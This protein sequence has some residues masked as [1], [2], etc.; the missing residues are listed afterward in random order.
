M[1]SNQKIRKAVAEMVEQGLDLLENDPPNDPTPATK[2]FR[3]NRASYYDA[4]WA[5]R[6]AEQT[7]LTRRRQ[8]YDQK[9]RPVRSRTSA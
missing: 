6:D 8:I 1:R 2:E 5:V 7:E 9:Y 3:R 4:V